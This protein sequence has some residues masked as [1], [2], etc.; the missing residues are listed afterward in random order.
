[1]IYLSMDVDAKR[2]FVSTAYFSIFSFLFVRIVDHWVFHFDR[3]IDCESFVERREKHLRPPLDWERVSTPVVCS[4]EDRSTSR[5]ERDWV[6]K[7]S[8]LEREST[9][10]EEHSLTSD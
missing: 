6:G 1:M 10:D 3:R 2:Q 8:R 9:V 7:E 4:A 5:R